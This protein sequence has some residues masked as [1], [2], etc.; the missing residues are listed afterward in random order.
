MISEKCTIKLSRDVLLRVE[1][2]YVMVIVC[3]SKIPY[4]Q[5]V[6]RSYL[7]DVLLVLLVLLFT[8]FFNL[9][10]FCPTFDNLSYIVLH[11]FNLMSEPF[12]IARQYNNILHHG[13]EISSNLSSF[14]VPMLDVEFQAKLYFLF[15]IPKV[16]GG[17]NQV[18][19]V[20]SLSGFYHSLA[21]HYKGSSC[22]KLG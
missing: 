11:I 19:P 5:K 8:K 15:Y 20:V 7:P 13:F 3:H 21:I 6:T 12:L 16:L 17:Q 4:Y 18:Y 14:V 10:Y 1:V 9:S 2:C 22:I